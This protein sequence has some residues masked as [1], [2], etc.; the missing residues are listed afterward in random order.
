MKFLTRL[1]NSILRTEEMLRE[2]RSIL[3][4]IFKNKED[5]QNCSNY[6]GIMLMS[7]S[8]KLWECVVETRLRKEVEICE[9]QYSFMPKKGAKDAIFGL[10][11]LMEK[12]TEGQ[13]QLYCVFAD[14]EK[15]YNRVPREELFYCMRRSGLPEKYVRVVQDMYKDCMTVVWCAVGTTEGFGVE[16]GLHQGSALSPLLFY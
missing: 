13:E 8:M 3:V 9:Q 12:Y 11:I 6:R 7:H 14:L 10:R 1:F 5:V 15:A 4:P 16:V 2:W